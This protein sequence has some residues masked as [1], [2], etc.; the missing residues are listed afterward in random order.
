MF[1]EEIFPENPT[2][3]EQEE[4]DPVYEEPSDEKSHY[5]NSE[6]QYEGVQN[7]DPIFDDQTKEETPEEQLEEKQGYGYGAPP[8]P[9][10]PRGDPPQYRKYEHND[11]AQT[12]EN[13]EETPQSYSFSGV[14]DE[15]LEINEQQEPEHQTNEELS[16]HE[17][18]HNENNNVHDQYQEQDHQGYAHSTQQIN[19]D[20]SKFSGEDAQQE[21]E[22]YASYDQAQQNIETS[23]KENSGNLHDSK[24]NNLNSNIIEGAERTK[25]GEG[26]EEVP[27]PL[28]FVAEIETLS[29]L[30]KYEKIWYGFKQFADE[31]AAYFEKDLGIPYPF[32]YIVFIL[33][34]IVTTYLTNILR[35][36]L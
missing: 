22:K 10:I 31:S 20:E 23:Q 25:L 6:V 14:D 5:I 19:E 33:V 11:N 4:I 24:L 2:M 32:N 30:M 36:L 18:N 28:G 17:N 12:Q 9:Y 3:N 8:P 13:I 35:G 7:I 29:L 16:S 21:N 1:S 34:T 26:A 15:N 27:T